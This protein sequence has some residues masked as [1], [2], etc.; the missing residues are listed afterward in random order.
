MSRWTPQLIDRAIAAQDACE[1]MTEWARL[2]RVNKS[3]LYRRMS[4]RRKE[5][6]IC[7]KK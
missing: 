1:N 7:R 2:M 4:Q 3:S 6:G 5:R